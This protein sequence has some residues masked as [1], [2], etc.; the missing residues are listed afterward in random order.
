MVKKVLAVILLSI[1]FFLWAPDAA[2]VLNAGSEILAAVPAVENLSLQRDVR[3]YESLD[4]DFQ[5]LLV[6]TGFYYSSM[7][8]HPIGYDGGFTVFR[9]SGSTAKEIGSKCGCSGLTSPFDKVV[10][11]ISHDMT[12]EDESRIVS[13]ELTHVLQTVNGVVFA[14]P[15]IESEYQAEVISR[16]TMTVITS[17]SKPLGPG[18][19]D[20]R[21]MDD[22]DLENLRMLLHRLGD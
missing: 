6:V 12:S 13:H 1:G 20:T 22:K 21:Q 16:F 17:A 14:M 8:G 19:L 11:I 18:S 9:V 10:I 4:P 7:S 2:P 5:L 3:V 15:K